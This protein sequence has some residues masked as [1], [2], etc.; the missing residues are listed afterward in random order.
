MNDTLAAKLAHTGF[1]LE[2]KL[3]QTYRVSGRC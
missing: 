2:A 1:I 3:T